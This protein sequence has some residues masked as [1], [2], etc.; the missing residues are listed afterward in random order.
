MKDIAGNF[1][2]SQFTHAKQKSAREPE[3]KAVG[4]KNFDLSRHD[5]PLMRKRNT[6]TSSSSE[7]FIHNDDETT[8]CSSYLKTPKRLL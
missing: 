7:E 8:V 2:E 4:S 6:L 3:Q 1:Q 5:R